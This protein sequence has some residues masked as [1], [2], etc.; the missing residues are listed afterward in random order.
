MWGNENGSEGAGGMGAG[1]GMWRELGETDPEPE[2]PLAL[3]GV[4]WV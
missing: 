1:A 2:Y 4:D 3:L